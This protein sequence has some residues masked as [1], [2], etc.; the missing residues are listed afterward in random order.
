LTNDKK[1]LRFVEIMPNWITDIAKDNFNKYTLRAGY[2][3]PW[4]RDAKRYD[5]FRYGSHFSR[6]EEE[7]FLRMNQAPLP[8]SI[9]TAICDTAEALMTASK[10]TVKVAPLIN[11]LKPELT[12][13]SKSVSQAYNYLLERD[14]HDS[15]GSLQ[16]DRVIRDYNNVGH[17]LY[18]ITPHKEFGEFKTRFEH[19]P[20][21]F[22]YPD[23]LTR[24]PF[25][26]TSD[27]HLIAMD[28]S[29]K[30]GYAIVRKYDP[31]ITYEKYVEDFVKGS[32]FDVRRDYR[33][34][35]KYSPKGV[36][37]K[38]V[39]FARDFILEEEEL[40]V[41][42][43]TDAG[44]NVNQLDAGFK[45]Y[46]KSEIPEH[47]NQAVDAKRVRLE[48][49]KGMVL[50]EKLSVGGRGIKKIYNIDEYNIIP[51]V[52]D[53][54][55]SPYPIGRIHYLYPL[56]R[57]INKFIMTAILNGSIMNAT[58][59][60]AEEDSIINMD[61]FKANASNPGAVFKYRLPIP[62]VSQPPQIIQAQPLGEAWLA[63]PK[64]LS[65][66][67]EYISGIFGAM[68]G[69]S[70]ESPDVFSTVASLQSAGGEKMK[71]R[72]A[73][74]DAALSLAGRV[75]GKFYQHY[76]PPNA[77]ATTVDENGELKE[78]LIYNRVIPVKGEL[79]KVTIED[80][81]NL[82]YG[83][84]SVRFTSGSSTGYESA[85]QA[86]LLTNLATQLK[87]PQLVPLILKRLNLPDVDDV[88]KKLDTVTQQEGTIEQMAQKIEMLEGETK[89][90]AKRVTQKT[91]ELS[92]EQ[93]D[94][95]FAEKKGQINSEI[96]K[97]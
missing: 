91:F 27:S 4:E 9:T 58:R 96:N 49:K 92:K 80:K 87:V 73:Q 26:R 20:W 93:F 54:R 33:Y 63:M 10:P 39:L 66:I 62:G 46:V 13:I 25:Y 24:D 17:G 97:G 19:L 70:R 56:Q 72:L 75:A 76:A 11:P 67:M 43:P 35:N 79:Q 37:L 89:D 23:P 38:G 32:R 31:D 95:W 81:T 55:D 22:Y 52:Y 16:H 65:Y 51:V 74:A 36:K 85:T 34:A 15:L 77:Y 6:G 47:V 60:M 44:V 86:A 21:Q 94:T 29:E 84:R 30:A 71:R 50:T 90:M 78:P 8:I 28:I 57:A 68:M 88:V 18:M 40:V 61:E 83:F 69:D 53:H 41:V 12:D 1:F 5:A 42:I 48:S 45:T 59:V 2:R 82:S 64:Y 7:T 14:W 3:F